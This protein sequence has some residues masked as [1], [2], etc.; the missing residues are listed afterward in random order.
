MPLSRH[1]PSLSLSL[2]LSLSRVGALA[3]ITSH[4]RGKEPHRVLILDSLSQNGKQNQVIHGIK[5]LL[6]V[7]FQYETLLS[8]VSFNFLGHCF[9]GGDAFMSAISDSTG[10]RSRDEGLFKNWVN[11]GENGVMQHSIAYRRFVNM[12]L[13]RIGYIKSRVWAVFISLIPQLPVK[14]KNIFFQ[15]PLKT[16]HVGLVSFITLKSVPR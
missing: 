14:H 8:T 3:C 11:D 7:A 4:N 9:Q 16:N 12:P 2:S 6:N 1:S 13:F 15:L 5:K 10:E